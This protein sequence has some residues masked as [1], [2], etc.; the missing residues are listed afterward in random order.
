MLDGVAVHVC[1]TH[2]EFSVYA[3]VPGFGEEEI[4]IKVDSH[5]VLITGKQEE[6]SADQEDQLPFSERRPKTFLR[7]CLLGAEIEPEKVTAQFNDGVLQIHLPKSFASTDL[8][9]SAWPHRH[10][11]LRAL[12]AT[13]ERE[14]YD[15]DK[16]KIWN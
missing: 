5:R 4:S 7:E 6:P 1:E 9:G 8:L 10:R 13:T 14:P 12:L 16:M 3:M 15:L 2:D 11:R